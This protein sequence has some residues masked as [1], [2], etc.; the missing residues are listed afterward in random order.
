MGAAR[1]AVPDI[2]II[3]GHGS[4]D[5]IAAVVA[6]LGAVLAARRG[7]GPAPSRHRARRAQVTC[8]AVRTRLLPS[9]CA[10]VHPSDSNSIG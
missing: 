4:D 3:G 1:N 10:E 6:V 7:P 8:T 9:R 2:R 5:E